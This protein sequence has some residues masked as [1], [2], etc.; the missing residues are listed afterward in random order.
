M[1]KEG[2]ILSC[3]SLSLAATTTVM[4]SAT[5]AT[6][7]RQR[8]GCAM[9]ARRRSHGQPNTIEVVLSYEINYYLYCINNDFH[10]VISRRLFYFSNS[11]YPA[12]ILT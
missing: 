5:T 6:S 11:K 3:P 9:P 4:L 2:D 1:M 10:L 7:V 12:N 8:V